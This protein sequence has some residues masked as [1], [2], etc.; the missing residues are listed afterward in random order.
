M[1]LPRPDAV[2][3]RRPRFNLQV[4]GRMKPGLTPEAARADLTP[5][6]DALA[7]QYGDAR[8][9][10]SLSIQPLRDVLI[11]SELRLTS[12]LFLGASASRY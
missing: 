6:A 5:I 2:G 7:T 1:L 4:I 8:D 3:G 10:R 9:G 12:L 11:G